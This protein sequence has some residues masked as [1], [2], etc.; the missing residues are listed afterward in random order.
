MIFLFGIMMMM[1]A[2]LL[3][4]MVMMMTM[5]VTWKPVAEVISGQRPWIAVRIEADTSKEGRTCVK[6]VENHHKHHHQHYL[7]HGGRYKQG[8]TNLH[9]TLYDGQLSSLQYIVINQMW[10]SFVFHCD[11]QR[12]I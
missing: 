8:G 5:M 9:R 6:Q 1:M 2:M 3:M 11:H 12:Q 7:H 4:M 10:H